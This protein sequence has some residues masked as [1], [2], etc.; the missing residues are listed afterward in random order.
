MLACNDRN[1][2]VLSAILQVA[3]YLVGT[4]DHREVVV[5]E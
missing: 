5:R 4:T 1:T 2:N 3:V